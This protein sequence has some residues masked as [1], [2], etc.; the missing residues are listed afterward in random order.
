[1]IRDCPRCN[2]PLRYVI[3]YDDNGY[4]IYWCE[5]CGWDSKTQLESPGG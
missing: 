2:G 1:M 5:F 3:E 4:F